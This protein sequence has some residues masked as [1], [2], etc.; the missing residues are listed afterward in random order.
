MGMETK[1]PDETALGEE[2]PK[3]SEL[4]PEWKGHE[5]VFVHKEIFD[6]MATGKFC[7]K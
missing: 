7:P 3:Y 6:E 4:S 5:R 1:V 2:Y